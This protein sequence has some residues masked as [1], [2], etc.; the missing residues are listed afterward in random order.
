MNK[1]KISKINWNSILNKFVWMVLAA[2][3]YG[4]F[5]MYSAV[6]YEQPLINKD[7]QDSLQ[8]FKNNMPSEK[9]N[10]KILLALD[11][12][13]SSQKK[14]FNT[15]TNKLKSHDKTLIYI[16]DKIPTIDDISKEYLK[17]DLK[18]SIRYNVQDTLL[19]LE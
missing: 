8:C 19:T 17:E 7:F 2:I 1:V 5:S 9:S 12:L 6:K 10:N 18:A 3:V 15:I 11:T 16:I 4:L 13:A 14:G